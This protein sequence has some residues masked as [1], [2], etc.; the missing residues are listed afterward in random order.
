[1]FG[2]NVLLDTTR[3]RYVLRGAPHYEW[4]FSKERYFAQMI[5]ERT[6][7][8]A[9]WPYLINDA[10]DIFGWAYAIMPRLPGEQLQDPATRTARTDAD[11]L[12]I[13]AAMGEALALLQ[14]AT[15][16][17][18][19]WY[20]VEKGELAP[21]EKPFAEWH[22]DWTGGYWLDRC[23]A[24]STATTDGDVAWVRKVI[25]GSLDSLAVP[26]QPAIVHTD[27][28]EGNVVAQRDGAGIWRVTGVFDLMDLYM[29][30]GE[31]DI[32]RSY[33]SYYCRSPEI[34]RAFLRAYHALRPERPRFAER[35][36]M[37]MLHDRLIFWE[38]GQRNKL[39]FREGMTLR[40]WA[41]P[42]VE[43]E[44]VR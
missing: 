41:E 24:A 37:Y 7:V 43:M 25:E 36:P 26:L 12:G 34:A 17:V 11:R 18:H 44:I 13:A 28:T 16:P 31:A 21:L 33:A 2:Q 38:Y 20:D 35:F 14:E 15:W 42:Q 8:P 22:A 39:W 19:A 27:Y 1:L 3:G 4:Q 23:R 29:G 30:D 9:P 10:T 32:V 6:R 5:R 40:D